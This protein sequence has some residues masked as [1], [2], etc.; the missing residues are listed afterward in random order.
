MPFKYPVSLEVEGRRCVV[1]GGGVVGEQKAKGLL[2]A[3]AVVVVIA[4]HFTRELEH[5]GSIGEVELLRREYRETDLPGAFLAIAA[6][7]DST[8]NRRIYEDAERHGVLLNAVDD[9]ENCHFAIPSIVRRGDFI[10]AISTGGNAP[11]LSKRLRQS[12]AKEF[13]PEYSSLVE[14]LG[15]IREELLPHR[16][17]FESW[18]EAW[19]R[20]L[21]NDLAGLVAEGKLEEAERLV[22]QALTA[23]PSQKP[24]RVWLVG[25]GPGDPELISVKG[26]RAIDAA[27]VVV[28]DRLVDPSLYRGKR[29]ISVGK[30]P[31][32]PSVSQHEINELLVGLAKDGQKVVR[33]KGGDPFVF[34]RGS[35]EAEALAEAGIDFD[36]ISA[37]TS[38]I[39][40]PAAAG[41][42][43]TDRRFASSV[44]IVTGTTEERKVNYRALAGA[45]ETI[46]I[47]MGVARLS[48]ITSE[49]VDGG[50]DPSTPAAVIKD[51]TLPSQQV[52]VGTIGEISDDAAQA[53]ISA[54]AVIVVGEVVRVR[55]RVTA[56]LTPV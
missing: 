48:D 50:L 9:I 37:P 22:R 6:T 43:V 42:P 36:V 45:T 49:L 27:D 33:L 7:D 41:I 13:G 46:V 34:G 19:Q 32:K 12:L 4:P 51:G 28:H 20:A 11:A 52:V 39:A 16:P 18:A 35:E 54:P 5:L 10:I 17:D 8:I 21:D 14:L 1:I 23:R 3:G 24:G 31:G 38:A 25:A 26:R 55:E 47:L 15:R 44:A 53:G 56:T 2:D 29:A 40:V 30:E